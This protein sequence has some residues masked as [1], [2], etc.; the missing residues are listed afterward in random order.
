MPSPAI[1]TTP[2]PSQVVVFGVYKHVAPVFKPTPDDARPL[3]PVKVVNATVSPGFTDFVWGVATGAFGAATVGVIVALVCWLLVSVTTY[4]TGVA[5]P[6]NV[7]SG[8]NVTVPSG[9]TVYVPSLGTTSESKLHEL[10]A[11]DVVKHNFKV[12]GIYVAGAVVVSLDNG[13][14]TWLVSYAPLGV[15]LLATGAAGITGVKVD[16]DF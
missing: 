9:L 13:E 6:L 10:L 1:T 8:S 12:L 15:S 3:V 5:A 16:V 2:S 4:F 14:I 7:G 11:D